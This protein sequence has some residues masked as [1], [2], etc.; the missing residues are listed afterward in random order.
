MGESPPEAKPIWLATTQPV[1]MSLV[2][3]VSESRF[4]VWRTIES[5]ADRW[6]SLGALA[7]GLVATT[8]MLL[9]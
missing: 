7:V 6:T 9:F 1:V 5:R 2:A 4:A 3:P 8:A